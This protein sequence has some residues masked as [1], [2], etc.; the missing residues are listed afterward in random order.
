MTTTN[1]G[2]IETKGQAELRMRAVSQ[3]GYGSADVLEIGTI[4]RPTPEPNEVLIEVRAAAVDRGTCHLMT[5]TPYLLRLA[6][7]GLT[8]PKH[9]IAGLD[10]AGRSSPSAG[11]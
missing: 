1:I 11:T 9:P 10:V 5:G 6:G 7:Y 8:K 3:N 2:T 4:D